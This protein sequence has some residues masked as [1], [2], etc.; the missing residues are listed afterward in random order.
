MGAQ[1]IASTSP[2][3]IG[4]DVRCIRKFCTRRGSFLMH[5]TIR[6]SKRKW[7][8]LTKRNM[9]QFIMSHQHMSDSTDGQSAPF[10]T[11]IRS[12]NK[13]KFNKDAKFP[14]MLPK[15][16][17][18][19]PVAAHGTVHS[20]AASEPYL[21]WISRKSAGVSG[22]EVNWL[23]NASK[24]TVNIVNLVFPGLVAPVLRPMIEPS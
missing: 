15:T 10:T 20:K 24:V 2:A 13:E 23:V 1:T 14:K 19:V 16:A 9:G 12:F 8:M 21:F 17:A 22:N 7:C 6:P 11:S 4:L 5:L 18:S 3:A